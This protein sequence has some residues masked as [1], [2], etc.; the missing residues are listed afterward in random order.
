MILGFPNFWHLGTFSRR[1][2]QYIISLICELNE[3][4][5]VCKIYLDCT[6]DS[7]LGL[8]L[9]IFWS[10]YLWSD[11][12]KWNIHSEIFWPLKRTMVISSL[13]ERR[14]W[15]ASVFNTL[16]PFTGSKFCRKR[17]S[18]EQ[19][20]CGELK[21]HVVYFQNVHNVFLKFDMRFYLDDVRSKT[22]LLASRRSVVRFSA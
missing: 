7:I 15:K 16:K 1:K 18:R 11:F 13:E 3:L 17:S 20:T 22:L 9:V 5:I 21:I 14:T 8:F 10:S 12:D 19:F 4:K 6:L 2:I